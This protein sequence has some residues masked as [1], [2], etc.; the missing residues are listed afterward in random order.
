MEEDLM[1]RD[2]TINAL[3]VNDK[4]KLSIIY[5]GIEEEDLERNHSLCWKSDGAFLMNALRMMRA[6]RF[7][8]Q[9]VFR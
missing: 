4:K 8:G 9:L 3:A 5:G 2:F 7:A 1:R 6:V